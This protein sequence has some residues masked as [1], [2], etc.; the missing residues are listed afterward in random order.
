MNP[1][2]VGTRIAELRKDKNMTQQQLADELL[3]SNKAVS[4]WENGG[5]LPDIATIP[6]LAEVLGV[7]TDY[8]LNENINDTDKIKAKPRYK[9]LIVA[10]CII[11]ILTISTIIALALNNQSEYEWSDF[12]YLH[13]FS[14]ELEK[15]GLQF[16]NVSQV[17]HTTDFID[18]SNPNIG[19]ISDDIPIQLSTEK[20]IDLLLAIYRIAH[21]QGF[22]LGWDGVIQ[23][24][25]DLAGLDDYL[26]SGIRE[27]SRE[28]REQ[29][30]IN[31]ATE[32]TFDELVEMGIFIRQNFIEEFHAL[33]F[34]L[35]KPV[36][37]YTPMDDFDTGWVIENDLAGNINSAL[38][39]QDFIY[40]CAV[41]VYNENTDE[42][43]VEIWFEMPDN[44]GELT[45]REL[46]I[47][48][49]IIR[50]FIPNIK[51]ENVIINNMSV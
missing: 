11:G 19:R 28:A 4:K 26:M 50:L 12:I 17:P 16:I 24:A 31:L 39:L 14:E 42:P 25:I 35:D 9:K 1:K 13:E 21:L 37:F 34:F 15:R 22:G 27:I 6:K 46:E 49:D 51:D 38:F 47:I 36:D 29:E 7:K 2:I 45:E 5:G 23:E 41:Q 3:V 18:W 30:L 10:I 8:L 48:F 20:D 32:Y 43:S 33:G 40:F 44:H